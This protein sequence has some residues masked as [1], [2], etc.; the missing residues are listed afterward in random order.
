MSS[1][2][3]AGYGSGEIDSIKEAVDNWVKVKKEYYPDI[4]KKFYYDERYMKFIE[5]CKKVINLKINY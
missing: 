1:A 3:L 2:V 5:V 4:S